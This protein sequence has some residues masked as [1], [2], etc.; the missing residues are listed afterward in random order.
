MVNS[1]KL[2]INE[3]PMVLLPSLAVAFGVN[4]AVLLQQIQYWITNPKCGVDHKGRR[5]VYNSI[6]EWQ[7]QMPFWSERT[8]RRTLKNLK[9][10][11]VVLCDV[12]N[13]NAWNKTPHY[14]I[15]YDRLEELS[16]AASNGR[17]EP[18]NMDAS[19]RSTWPRTTGQVGR[20]IN[21][22]TE[23]TSETTTE[24]ITRVTATPEEYGLP[25]PAT[26][27]KPSDRER[28]ARANQKVTAE[29]KAA[30]ELLSAIRAALGDA[31]A[32]NVP[33]TQ[34]VG[35]LQRSLTGLIAEN[36]TTEEIPGLVAAMRAW[37]GTYAITPNAI[38]THLDKLRREA[39]RTT[40]SSCAAPPPPAAAPRRGRD[41][42]R[43]RF[44]IDPDARFA[45]EPRVGL[46]AEIMGE[47]F[48]YEYVR[49]NSIAYLALIC[50][51]GETGSQ[52]VFEYPPLSPDYVPHPED[53]QFD[54]IV[55]AAQADY[56][57]RGLDASGRVVLRVAA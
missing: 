14:S 42:A 1:S 48:A 9:D 12:F 3:S 56:Q 47:D 19:N 15:D 6:E 27:P 23:T 16:H 24:I 35:N 32:G 55:E 25:K 44:I 18:A 46:E 20:D 33:P 57:R 31:P 41:F 17:V 45:S 51:L 8:I 26:N 36:V 28:H 50:Q 29:Y 53:G 49:N 4:E 2:L 43:A 22:V 10:V 13:E 34:M 30:S 21:K 54:Y 40:P 39:R 5:W 7:K 11:G 37:G 52:E 38:L